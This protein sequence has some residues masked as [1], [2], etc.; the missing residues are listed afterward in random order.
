NIIINSAKEPELTIEMEDEKKVVEAVVLRSIRNPKLPVNRYALVSGRSFSPEETQR[1]AA[2]VND[3]S[4][5]ALGFPGVQATRDTRSD[6]VIRGNNPIGM[7]WKLE[8]LDV[9]N[10]NHF[11]RRGGTGGGITILRD[12]KSVV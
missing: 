7:Q 8:G 4:R 5:M 9:I 6:I 2:S 11:A 1:Y 10:P 12:R 3:P